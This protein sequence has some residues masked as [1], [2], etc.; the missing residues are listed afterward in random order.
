M[1]TQIKTLYH[2]FRA[3]T[4]SLLIYYYFTYIHWYKTYQPVVF[5]PPFHHSTR[6]SH[7]AQHVLTIIAPRHIACIQLQL[8][9]L[10]GQPLAVCSQACYRQSLSID[11]TTPP[12]LIASFRLAQTAELL[13]I[14]PAVTLQ[15]SQ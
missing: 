11:Q 9:T 8:T 12:F 15:Q 5:P 7:I 10:L 4:T 6:H 3:I 1:Y 14:P 13:T 2:Y